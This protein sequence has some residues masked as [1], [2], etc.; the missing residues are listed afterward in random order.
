MLI[1]QRLLWGSTRHA[2]QSRPSAFVVLIFS[3]ALQLHLRRRGQPEQEMGGDSRCWTGQ[4]AGC[5]GHVIRHPNQ[6]HF[7]PAPQRCDRDGHLPRCPVHR[8]LEC[9]SAS[10]ERQK[11]PPND[12]PVGMDAPGEGR[13]PLHERY[14]RA[15]RTEGDGVRWR[16]SLISLPVRT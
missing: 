6:E 11:R 4:H 5:L 7:Q 16:C 14:R 12:K 3:G 1:Q 15:R 2:T 8:N 10:R 9:S 13:G